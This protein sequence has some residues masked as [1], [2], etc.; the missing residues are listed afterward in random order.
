MD[1]RLRGNDKW[2]ARKK[3]DAEEK[4]GV[5]GYDFTCHKNLLTEL[6]YKI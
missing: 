4:K 6:D 2:K 1:S 3:K 5:S